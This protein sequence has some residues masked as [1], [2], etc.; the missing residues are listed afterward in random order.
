MSEEANPF[1]TTT[2]WIVEIMI[3]YSYVHFVITNEKSTFT[4]VSLSDRGVKYYSWEE[5]YVKSDFGQWKLCKVNVLK[6]YLQIL[7][8]TI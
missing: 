4:R 5:D 2:Q 7:I 1:L 8:L 6:N 3:Q